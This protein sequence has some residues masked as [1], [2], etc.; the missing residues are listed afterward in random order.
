MQ[1]KALTL[2][3]AKRVAAAAEAKA[4]ANKWKVVIAIVDDGGHLVYLQRA[5]GTQFGSVKVAIG[6]AYSASA[7]K[8]HTKSWEERLADGRMGY[9]SLPGVVLLEGGLPLN[10]DGEV[11]GGIGVSGVKSAEDAQIAEAGAAVLQ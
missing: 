5:D 10:A 8:R 3:M 2:E 9:L 1:K 7:F 4:N 6:K 11:I